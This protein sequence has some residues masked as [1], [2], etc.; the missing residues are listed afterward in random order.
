MRS[1]RS[2]SVITVVRPSAARDTAAA[3]EGARLVIVAGLGHDL[4]R[5]VWPQVVEE[6]RAVADRAVT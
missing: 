3:I 6:I 1:I 5:D 4:P 2:S